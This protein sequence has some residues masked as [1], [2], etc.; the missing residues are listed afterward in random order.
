[1]T[2]SQ[3]QAGQAW[4]SGDLF[5]GMACTPGDE[6]HGVKMTQI[7]RCHAV[8]VHVW[9]RAE[10]TTVNKYNLFIKRI[11]LEGNRWLTHGL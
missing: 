6:I 2:G 3:G 1:M 4:S 7:Y 8:D 10:D 11:T 9:L 5:N